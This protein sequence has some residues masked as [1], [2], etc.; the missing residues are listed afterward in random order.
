MVIPPPLVIWHR[1]RR[2]RKNWG[3]WPIMVIPPL[4]FCHLR[5]GG[6][7]NHRIWVDMDRN[8]LPGPFYRGWRGGCTVKT[9]APFVLKNCRHSKNDKFRS[10]KKVSDRSDFSDHPQA[11][12]S[13]M[14]RPHFAKKKTGKSDLS[15]YRPRIVLRYSCVVFGVSNCSE[16][17]N[18][19]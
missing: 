12:Q 15:K 8:G 19:S 17:E 3:I 6:G 7:Y 13:E 18:W 10:F 9:T 16:A 4:V 2:R 5:T 14:P 11:T 1:A